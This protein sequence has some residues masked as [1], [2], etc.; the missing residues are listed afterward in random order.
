L[1]ALPQPRAV[2]QSGDAQ[3]RLAQEQS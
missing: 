2:G 1:P 3:D